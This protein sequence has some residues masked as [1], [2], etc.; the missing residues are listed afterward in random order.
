[1][2][3]AFLILSLISIQ[4]FAQK[5]P[6]VKLTLRDGNVMSG[7]TKLTNVVLITDYGK[8]DIPIKSVSSIAVGIPGDK[9]LTDKIAALVK[10]LNNSN[11][12]M[13][14]N[15][16][17]E[18]TGLPI[19]AVPVLSDYI[20]SPKYEASS[21]TDYNADMALSEMKGKFNISDD[22]N[23]KDIV[24]MDFQ[25]TMGG[26]YDF[27]KI[28]LKTEYGQLSIPKEK[29]SQIDIIYIPGEGGDMSFTLQGS[30]HI[31]SNTTGGWLK[32]GIM[33]KPGQKFSIFATGE[34]TL[35]SLSGNKYKPDGTVNGTN[36][37]EGED[38]GEGGN[39]GGNYP[40]Y[41][42]VVY[43]VGENGTLMKAG[44]KFS[45]SSPTG[46]MLYISIYETVYNAT[47]TGSY[48]VKVNLK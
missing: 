16:Y 26:V 6:E 40:V 28:D 4:C 12:E 21:F 13:R 41:G 37:V 20:F 31:S 7:T 33:L 34:V 11:E 44:A 32:T 45:G 48:S 1:M 24:T 23:A 35:A 19:G 30:K 18:L 42:N 14:K 47:N 38:G 9:S 8:L 36:N 10:Q 46:G 17:S 3:T 29:I 5:D 39:T 43:K 27:K 25:Y 15:A 2:K 22:F